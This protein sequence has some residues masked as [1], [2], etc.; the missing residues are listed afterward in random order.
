MSPV[1][2]PSGPDP[3]EDLRALYRRLQPPA[4]ADE[5]GAADPETARVVSWMRTAYE[6]L[7]APPSLQPERLRRSRSRARLVTRGLQAAAA[8][9]FLAGAALLWRALRR[10]EPAGLAPTAQQH[11]G[12]ARDSVEFL[13]VRPDHLVLRSGPVRLVLLEPPTETSDHSP[14]S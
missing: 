5:A 8:V 11:S 3:A 4:P 6:G 13:E 9:L 7:S 1:H 14:G 12:R 10:T 2:D